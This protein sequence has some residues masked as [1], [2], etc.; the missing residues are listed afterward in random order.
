MRSKPSN[1]SLG[2]SLPLISLLVVILIFFLNMESKTVGS[3]ILV[4]SS[5]IGTREIIKCVRNS[6]SSA[7]ANGNVWVLVSIFII[8][9]VSPLVRQITNAQLPLVFAVRDMETNMN[10][11]NLLASVAILSLI[12]GSRIYLQTH[13]QKS[14]RRNS[15]TIENLRISILVSICLFM[16]WMSL[17]FFWAYSQGNPFTAIFGSRNLQISQGVIKKNG[18][19]VDS[20]YGAF[21]VISAWLA[22]SVRENKPKVKKMLLSICLILTIPSLLQGDRSKNVF[23]LLVI[24]V[25]LIGWNKS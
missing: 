2:L 25:I 3:L 11:V 5:L 24:Y 21:G 9:L 6:P 10:Q 15:L 20:I 19:L 4:F 14:P 13:N 1:E 12:F 17:Y 22:F 7:I 16:F 8:F 18:Y 23:L